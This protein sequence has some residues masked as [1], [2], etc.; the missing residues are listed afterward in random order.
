MNP[1]F[2]KQLK[3]LKAHVEQLIVEMESVSIDPNRDDDLLL[4]ASKQRIEL[5]KTLAEI[6]EKLN[7]G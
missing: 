2:R 6:E 1:E 7:R 3:A 4:R 5:R